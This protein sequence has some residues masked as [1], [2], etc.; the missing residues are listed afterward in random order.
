MT[1]ISIIPKQGQYQLRKET[2]FN[3]YF[4][5]KTTEQIAGF[6][7]PYFMSIVHKDVRFGLKDLLKD[8][9]TVPSYLLEDYPTDTKAN[10]E[11]DVQFIKLI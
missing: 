6:I 1:N 9:K 2:F 8:S 11:I 3:W 4:K 5:N 10:V 7:S